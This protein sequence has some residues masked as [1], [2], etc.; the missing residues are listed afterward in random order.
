MR[1]TLNRGIALLHE[2]E[3]TLQKFISTVAHPVLWSCRHGGSGRNGQGRIA[4]LGGLGARV[5]LVAALLLTAPLWWSCKN[6]GKTF[7]HFVLFTPRRVRGLSVTLQAN[8]KGWI[9]DI[10]IRTIITKQPVS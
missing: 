1:H 6:T 5:V 9:T 3:E 4:S 10:L 7:L 8:A 2:L